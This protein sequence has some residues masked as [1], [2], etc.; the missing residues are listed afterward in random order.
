M[1]EDFISRTWDEGQ[2]LCYQGHCFLSSMTRPS[3]R[4][5]VTAAHNL[6]SLLFRGLIYCKLFKLAG[7]C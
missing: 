4:G 2:G 7:Q 6:G 5:H 1:A 3:P